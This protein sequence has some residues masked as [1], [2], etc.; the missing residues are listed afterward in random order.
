MASIFLDIIGKVYANDAYC[1]D[2]NLSAK[3]RLI[4]HQTHSQPLMDSLYIWLNNQLT[5][6]LTEDNGGLGQAVKYM[7][8]HRIPLTTFLRVAGSPLDSSWAERAIKIAIRYRRTALF[9]K[10]PKG[11]KV[12]DCLMSIIYT[13][14]QNNVNP[15]DYLNAL[16]RYGPMMQDKPECW[17]PWNYLQTIATLSL[18]KAA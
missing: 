17:L 9:Y 15:Y 5:Y 11:A 10:T 6:A 16:Q 12:G 3:E 18:N 2:K 1:K 7:L 13:C 14:N 4:Y 8:R